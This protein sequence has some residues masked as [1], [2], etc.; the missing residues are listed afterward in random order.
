MFC[1]KFDD[2]PIAPSSVELKWEGWEGVLVIQIEL[3]TALM[4]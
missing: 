4:Q 3:K 1:T 2:L